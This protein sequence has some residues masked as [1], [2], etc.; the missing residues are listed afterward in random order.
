MS[1]DVVMMTLEPE[2]LHLVAKDAVLFRV[3]DPLQAKDTARGDYSKPIP[4]VM[5]PLLRW[6]TRAF[7]TD[8]AAAAK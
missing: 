1:V 7:V 8:G 5:R 4:G 6:T 2:T 3:V